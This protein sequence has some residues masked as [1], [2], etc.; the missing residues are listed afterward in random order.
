MGE[1][2]DQLEWF[3]PKFTIAIELRGW[4]AVL[5]ASGARNAA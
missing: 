3:Q 1:S 4:T 2:H 5:L